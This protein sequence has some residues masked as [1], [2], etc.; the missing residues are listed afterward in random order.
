MTNYG[1]NDRKAVN[2]L[3]LRSRRNSGDPIVMLT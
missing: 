1:T 2:I 3:D